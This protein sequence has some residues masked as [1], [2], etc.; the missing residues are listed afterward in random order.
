VKPALNKKLI[1]AGGVF[2]GLFLGILIAFIKEFSKSLDWND[3]KS[4]K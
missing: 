1:L 2:M 3:I 4:K